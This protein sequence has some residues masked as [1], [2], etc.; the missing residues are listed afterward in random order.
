MLLEIALIVIAPNGLLVVCLSHCNCCFYTRCFSWLFYH[1]F[2]QHFLAVVGR[3]PACC[4]IAV[5]SLFH[6]PS[7]CCFISR[8]LAVSSAFFS[9]FHLPSSRCFICR[10]LTV[11]SAIFSLFHLPSSRCFICRLLA[12]LS[13]IFLFLSAILLTV[14]VGCSSSCFFFVFFSFPPLFSLLHYFF[15]LSTSFFW[16]KVSNHSLIFNRVRVAKSKGG[17]LFLPV[18]YVERL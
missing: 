7:S 2:C 13:A 17:L 1:C 18:L 16:L 15:F 6:L 12:V 9:L 4:F 14:I 11:S 3:L 5:F 10:L 8:L